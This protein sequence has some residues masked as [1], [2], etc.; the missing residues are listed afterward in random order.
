MWS[1]YNQARRITQF[2]Q[3]AKDVPPISFRETDVGDN[4]RNR[5]RPHEGERVRQRAR[6]IKAPALMRESRVEEATAGQKAR[7]FMGPSEV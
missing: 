5:L 3:P 4:Y 7:H 1:E 6:C 2:A